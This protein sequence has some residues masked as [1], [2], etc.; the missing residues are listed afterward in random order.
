MPRDTAVL[1][2]C[3]DPCRWPDERPNVP[4]NW[5]GLRGRR[6]P[7]KCGPPNRPLAGG[8]PGHPR[9]G[10][11]M[12]AAAEGNHSYSECSAQQTRLQMS[13]IRAARGP[14]GDRHDAPSAACP[15]V[16]VPGFGIIVRMTGDRARPPPGSSVNMDDKALA[17]AGR[18]LPG[19]QDRAGRLRLVGPQPGSDIVVAPAAT[20]SDPGSVASSTRVRSS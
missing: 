1:R 6:I 16:G 11:A 19:P 12:E 18:D 3:A 14:S 8:A 9:R 2:Y 13:G 5:V 10:Q 4:L 15:D 20:T 7:A 17:P